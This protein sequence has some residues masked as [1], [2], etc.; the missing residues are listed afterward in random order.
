MKNFIIK[1]NNDTSNILTI[2]EV[3]LANY[4]EIIKNK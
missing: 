2:E 3:V 4:E 1:D